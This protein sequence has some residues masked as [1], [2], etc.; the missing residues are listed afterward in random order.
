MRRIPHFLVAFVLVLESSC[1]SSSVPDLRNT[2]EVN[3][4]L[5]GALFTSILYNMPIGSTA[6]SLIPRLTRDSAVM[7]F[8][9]GSRLFR[10]S[11]VYP[12]LPGLV[13]Y[14]SP[15]SNQ[16]YPIYLVTFL[17][18]T[19]I[20]V[21]LVDSTFDDEHVLSC[22]RLANSVCGPFLFEHRHTHHFYNPGF[23][24]TEHEVDLYHAQHG[25]LEI[26][27]EY[28]RGSGL[29]TF[30]ISDTTRSYPIARRFGFSP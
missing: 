22:V 20:D 29:F 14:S 30:I 6:Q 8:N 17:R 19:C 7:R 12:W 26:S 16:V 11:V 15:D 2:P 3:L 28:R 23:T 21:T 13:T 10:D 25:S 1:H 4:T 5:G 9:T 27:M 18:D 24:I